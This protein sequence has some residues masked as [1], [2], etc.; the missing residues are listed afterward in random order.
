M[1][2]VNHPGVNAEAY[3]QNCGKA[4]C[5]TCVRREPT[6]QVMCEPCWNAWQ[7]A[8]A[9]YAAPPMGP[10]HAGCPSPI[11]AAVLGFIPGVGAMFNG[12]FL[13]GFLH[14][15]VF[16]VLAS[17]ADVWWA[18]GWLVAAWIFYQVF[19]AFQTAKAKCEGQPLP[20]PLGMNEIVNWLGH[21]FQRS[22]TAGP[23][24]PTGY[25]PPAANYS[26]PAAGPAQAQTSNP[27]QSG[28]QPPPYTPPAA[29]FVPNY[30]P[31]P[32]QGFAPPPAQGFAPPA[33]GFTPVGAPN[34]QPVPPMPHRRR[35]PVAAIVLI[36][37]GVLFLLGQFSWRAMHYAWPVLLIGL[38]AWLVVRRMRDVPP[39]ATPAS[40]PA[41]PSQEP[42]W[43]EM[44]N[45]NE[46]THGGA[47]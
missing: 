1:D 35:E 27:Y 15:I 45:S 14:V 41:A 31:P 30:P 8:R 4:M 34:M 6:G 21:E 47:Q 20:D 25:A 2:C 12:Q 19:D 9:P 37:M 39:M 43:E 22:R 28:Y 11:A 3:C 40:E 29:G 42:R 24:P 32:G 13:K 38:G 10:P 18:F 16:A 36:A 26:P 23:P 46:D 33:A 44:K 5:T 17:M 7:A